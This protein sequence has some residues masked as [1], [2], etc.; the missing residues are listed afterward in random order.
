[1]K[2]IK[3]LIS[4]CINNQ[5]SFRNFIAIILFRLKL[6]PNEYS[7]RARAL[8]NSLKYKKK[9]LKLKLKYDELGF[10]YLN[11]MPTRD[12]LNK[13]YKETYWLS[14]SD[15]NYPIRL[16]DIEHY[17]LLKKIYPD[18]DDVSKKILNFGAGHGGLSILLHAA[19]HEI[20][21]FDPDKINNLF[22]ERWNHVSNLNETNG[23]FDLIYG[24]HSL[25][26]VQNIKETMKKFNEIS[27]EN[28][29]F[30][31]EVPNCT[32]NVQI[33]PPHTYYFTR[34]FFYNYFSKYDYCDTS[35]GLDK[36]K[37]DE[38]SVIRFLSK[39]RIKENLLK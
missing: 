11:P 24:S 38:G 31:F 22:S 30:F 39:H 8:Y 13:Y 16:R 2:Y 33:S 6:I 9:F 34:K 5:T 29:I 37:N 3:K 10:Y 27:N 12:F 36:A 19:K 17:K 7:A 4:A 28:T 18:F 20:Y 1:M 15:K 32:N 25:E 14:R 26:H 35:S 21:N 23:K